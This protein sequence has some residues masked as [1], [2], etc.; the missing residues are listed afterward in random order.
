MEVA[1]RTPGAPR[2]GEGLT[3]RTRGTG[4]GMDD[5]TVEGRRDGAAVDAVCLGETMVMVTPERSAPLETAPSFVLRAGGAESNVAVLLS[6][7]GHTA[8]WLSRLGDD[9]LGRIVLEAVRRTGVDTSSVEVAQGE[10]T[11]V[12]F[13]DPAP[14]GTRVY[15]YRRSSAASRMGAELLPRLRDRTARL[16]HVTGITAALSDT[17]ARLI[18]EVV[19]KRAIG[20]GAVSFDVNYRPALWSPDQ[21]APVLLELARSADIAFV[22]LD[23]AAT[24][25]GT[26]TA[27]DVRRAVSTPEFLIVKDSDRDA[28]AFGPEG[29][30]Q[31]P[32]LQ[33][34]VVEPIGAG[35]AFAAG[36]LAG[37]LRDLP[38]TTRLRL[39]HLI[40]AVALSSTSDHSVVPGPDDLAARLEMHDDEWRRLAPAPHHAQGA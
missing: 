11:G 29:V 8:A 32:A 33:V 25:W 10:Q 7:L 31:V 24:L 13:K 40:A 5:A 23:E 39:G 16:V 18:D 1:T 3:P 4:S 37:W 26:T 27:A 17:C 35:D 28:V 36:W 30:Q 19:V 20:T 34:E 38:G 21:A 14:D 6:S 22:G 15:Y 9:P 12:Y 2:A